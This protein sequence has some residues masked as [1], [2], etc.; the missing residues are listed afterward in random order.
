M[1]HLD[2]GAGNDGLFGG[3]GTDSA[4]VDDSDRLRSVENI[5]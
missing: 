5:L 4:T 3:P 1:D 2:G